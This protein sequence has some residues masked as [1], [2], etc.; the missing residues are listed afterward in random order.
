MLPLVFTADYARPERPRARQ[1]PGPQHDVPILPLT[2]AELPILHPTESEFLSHEE[3]NRVMEVNVGGPFHCT[4]AVFPYM[5]D[6]GGKI[7]NIS[8]TTIF[9]GVPGL[10]VPHYITSKGAVMAFT[11]AMARTLGDNNIN[12]NSIAPGFTHSPGGY[13]YDKRN[14][15]NI[16]VLIRWTLSP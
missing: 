5:K 1:S 8:S 9:E 14:N 2:H 6:K 16:S 15:S 13:K 4:K 7:I 10:G 12:V 3:W 11:R